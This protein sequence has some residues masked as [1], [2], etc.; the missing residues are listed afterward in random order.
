MWYRTRFEHGEHVRRQPAA[1]T[2]GAERAEADA[3]QSRNGAG[4]QKSALYFLS[5]GP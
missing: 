5:A 3:N 2:V 1:Q 4:E